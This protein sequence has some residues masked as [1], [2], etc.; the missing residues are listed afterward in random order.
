[1]SLKTNNQVYSI[2]FFKIF[3]NYTKYTI[4]SN[5]KQNYILFYGVYTKF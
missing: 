3:K 5:L 4:F 1:M 2:D